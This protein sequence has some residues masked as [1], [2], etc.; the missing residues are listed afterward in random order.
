MI[1]GDLF[2]SSFSGVV[3]SKERLGCGGK[4]TEADKNKINLPGFA[5]KKPQRHTMVIYLVRG[6]GLEGF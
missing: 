4:R 5:A 1:V 6:M 3:R 2:Q